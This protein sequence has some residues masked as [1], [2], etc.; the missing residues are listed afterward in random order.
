MYCLSTLYPA[1]PYQDGESGPRGRRNDKQKRTR[2]RRSEDKQVALE[3]LLEHLRNVLVLKVDANARDLLA[4][5]PEECERYLKQ[6]AD[7]SS[8]DVSL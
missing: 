8:A 4:A 3:G 6:G 1:D 2:L 5:T 7:W